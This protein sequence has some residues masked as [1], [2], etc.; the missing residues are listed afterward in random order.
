MFLRFHVGFFWGIICGE[1]RDLLEAFEYIDHFESVEFSINYPGKWVP[2]LHGEP[3]QMGLEDQQVRM[4]T[5]IKQTWT[6]HPWNGLQHYAE[7]PW[8]N[9]IDT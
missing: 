1:L 8:P 5:M 6:A 7:L 3:T 9:Q 4:P 2:T